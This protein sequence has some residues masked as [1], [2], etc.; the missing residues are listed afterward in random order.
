MNLEQIRDAVRAPHVGDASLREELRAHIESETFPC[1]GAKSA[2][3]TD[4]LAIV[5]AWRLTSAA[6]DREIHA[7]L[8]N[9]SQQYKDDPTGLRSLAVMFE[10]P[11]DLSE[12]EFESA[13]WNRIQALSQ[14]DHM[15]GQAYCDDV[16]SD[17]DDPHFSLSFGGQGYFVV[18]LHPNASR[19]ARRVGFP[20]L[21]FNLHDQ[22]EQLRD[23][24]RYEKMREA[25]I[26]RDIDLQ[27]SAN[28]ML[29]RFGE[30][31]EAA[32]YSGRKVGPEWK[33]PFSDPRNA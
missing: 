9:W 2:L 29:N 27:G 18:G 12:A 31:S 14:R 8:L 33:C 6:D 4:R 10:G 13:M 3:A 30:A 7:A 20:T 32:Q 26:G 28:P 19:E 11:T 17:P 22:F 15:S 24:D 23:S 16:S 25:I 5:T 1:V 21:V